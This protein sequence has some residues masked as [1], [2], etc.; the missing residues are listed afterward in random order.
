M[1]NIFLQEAPEKGMPATEVLD[2]V[3]DKVI[4]NSNISSHPK[5]FYFVPEPSNF[6]SAMADSLATGF[7]I[8]S[9][10]WI[11]SP[12][13]AELEIVTINWLLK[14]FGFPVKKG[15][16]IFTSGG[17]MANLTA[18]VTARRIKC[19]DDFS[20][21]IRILGF[22][23]EQVKIIPID[24]EFKVSIN[25]LKNEIAKDQLEGKKT[26]L[27]HRFCG[28]YKYRYCRSFRYISRYL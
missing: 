11:V 22:S 9:G 16:G 19:G 5:A 15:G 8:F 17:S 7:N 14:M 24:L 25:K 20:K 2:F 18:L 6:I 21:A 3:M 10:G 23:K 27:Y 13:A 4:P 26:F 1:D 28:Y 12:A